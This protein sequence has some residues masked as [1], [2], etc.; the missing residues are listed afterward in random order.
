[1][2]IP[3]ACCSPRRRYATS[4]G[5]DVVESPTRS[6]GQKYIFAPFIRAIKGSQCVDATLSDA[7]VGFNSFVQDVACLDRMA[8]GFPVNGKPRVRGR[9][10]ENLI[11]RIKQVRGRAINL[12]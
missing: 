12:A 10:V 3:S 9:D 7:F 5:L 11:E 8:A 4:C 2:L 6:S 1:M